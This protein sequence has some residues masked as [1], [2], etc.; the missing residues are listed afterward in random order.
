[1]QSNTTENTSKAQQPE[2]KIPTY[3]EWREQRREWRKERREARHGFPFHGL[4]L[5]L[6][7]VLLG[8]L[9]LL[10]QAGWVTG[11]AWWQSLL[12]GLGV[13]SILNGM[14]YYHNPAYRWGSYGKFIVGIVMI[15][16]GTLFILGSSQWWPVA[17]IVAGIAFLIR[18]FWRR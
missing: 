3:R 11:D 18:F 6:V 14:A 7:L 1:M 5:G 2:G 16:I 12:I 8:V 15:I 13:I 9:F 4:F 10:S 17:L